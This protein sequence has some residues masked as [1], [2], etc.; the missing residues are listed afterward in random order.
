MENNAEKLT[1]RE[2]FCR[3]YD[4]KNVDRPPRC[5]GIYYWN[6]TITQWKKAGTFPEDADWIEYFGFEPY[7][8]FS[9]GLGVTEMA[10]SGPP[11]KKKLLKKDGYVET[12]ENDIGLV[13]Q[14]RTDCV[15][16]RWLKFPVEN[17]RDWIE[18]IKPRLNPEEHNYEI[19]EREVRSIK[20]RA[21][22]PKAFVFTGLYAFWRN[23]WG[24]EK[25]AYAFY[26][27]P[28]TLKDMAEVWLK[29]LCECSP[30][31]FEYIEVD[32]VMFHEDMAYKN[33]PLIGPHLFDSFMA[34]YYRELFAHL[35]RYGQKRFLLDSD[36]NNGI[37]LERFIELGMNG[38]FPFECAAGY[39]IV[40][41]RKEHPD[42]VIYGGID[43]RVL[44]KSKEDIKRE[45]MGK[46]PQIWKTG[47]F[48]PSIDHS[49]P[50]CPQEN[51][52]YL[53]E[54]IRGLF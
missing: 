28:E 35:R 31:G 24:E 8:C 36:G 43:K 48:I 44:F 39:D 22:Y 9:G 52:E 18:K 29:M 6:E 51:F 1:P 38:L 5:E 14:V 10:L 15:S 26:D 23:F 53:L 37:I 19:L 46:V 30:K 34:P 27:A 50:P 7:L 42:F 47:G 41:F 45:V 12:W 25:L 13:W 2:R 17:H 4:F 16:M 54:C 11:I 40:K 33:G 20:E 21:E 3:V 32:C 49:V